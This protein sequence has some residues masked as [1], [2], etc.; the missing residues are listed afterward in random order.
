MRYI[1]ILLF[2]IVVVSTTGCET[3]GGHRDR[4][5]SVPETYCV[6]DYV[7][8]SKEHKTVPMWCE[9]DDDCANVWEP[10]ANGQCVI[11]D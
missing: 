1:A 10:E 6:T 3:G 2:S 8:S 11:W 9:T 4:D 5:A 7:D